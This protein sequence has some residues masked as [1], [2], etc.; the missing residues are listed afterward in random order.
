M[1]HGVFDAEIWPKA[2]GCRSDLHDDV[3]GPRARESY[4]A[5]D[6]REIQYL[7]RAIKLC[8]LAIL[9]A[10]A[11]ILFGP[12]VSIICL[13]TVLIALGFFCGAEMMCFTGAVHYTTREN[14]GMTIG[15]VNTL[16]MLG[17]A[18]LQQGIG[19]LLDRQSGRQ[20]R[21]PWGKN[22]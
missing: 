20:R 9:I 1:G 11:F 16:N 17:G 7:N 6:L 14:S 5:L 8:G 18:L 19:W 15:V 22:L 2:R 4:F 13:S 21:Q 10:F 12:Q 3:P